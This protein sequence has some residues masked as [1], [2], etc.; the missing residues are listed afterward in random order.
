MKL[1]YVSKNVDMTVPVMTTTSSMQSQP[2]A[3]SSININNNNNNIKSDILNIN[4]IKILGPDVA[5]KTCDPPVV[6]AISDSPVIVPKMPMNNKQFQKNSD[7]NVQSLV[8][9]TNK[10][11]PPNKQLKIKNVPHIEDD[12]S[13]DIVSSKL[14]TIYLPNTCT[15]A[16]NVQVQPFVASPY[17]GSAQVPGAT[18]MTSP[19]S[20]TTH[21][22]ISAPLNTTAIT[23]IQIVP[24]TPATAAPLTNAPTL[25]SL[26]SMILTSSIHGNTPSPAPV[27]A[28]THTLLPATPLPQKIRE[29]RESKKSE[30]KEICNENI[31]L[32]KESE[33]APNNS[34]GSAAVT[35]MY[36]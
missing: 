7:H 31:V 24:M 34:I 10:N 27:L 16:I 23:P 3:I 30:E 26:P 19:A 22:M 21:C 28:S 35:G 8:L 13:T 5:E 36:L 6:S 17:H 1:S 2:N 20:P 12:D 9:D 25:G 18:Q 32:E 14:N 11:I 33:P 15:T 4:D 29:P